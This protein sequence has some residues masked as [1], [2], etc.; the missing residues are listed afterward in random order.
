VP[1]SLMIPA[2]SHSLLATFWQPLQEC[3]VLA[4]SAVLVTSDLQQ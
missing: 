1:E 4:F 2:L 3:F